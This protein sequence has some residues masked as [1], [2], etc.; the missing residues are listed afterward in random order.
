[1]TYSKFSDKQ[2][3]KFAEPFDKL[4]DTISGVG[5]KYLKDYER[6]DSNVLLEESKTRKNGPIVE[7]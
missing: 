4:S 2:A 3:Y 6:W 7:I 1:V 5:S